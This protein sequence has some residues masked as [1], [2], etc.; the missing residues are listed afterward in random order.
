MISFVVSR[1][2]GFATY[3]IYVSN[4][5]ALKTTNEIIADYLE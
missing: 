1:A 5:R 4:P 2:L 3:R